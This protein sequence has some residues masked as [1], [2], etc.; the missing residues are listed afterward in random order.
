MMNERPLH[1]WTDELPLTR[2][3]LVCSACGLTRR[4]HEPLYMWPGCYPRLYQYLRSSGGRLEVRYWWIK[5]QP[6]R[7]GRE[8]TGWRLCGW[9]LWLHRWTWRQTLGWW[10]ECVVGRANMWKWWRR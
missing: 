4:Y 3:Q 8:A 2:R 5:H 10:G 6:V 7:W 9:T 1:Q